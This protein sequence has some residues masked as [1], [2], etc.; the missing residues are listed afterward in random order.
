[1]FRFLHDAFLIDM[2]YFL[3]LRMKNV[4]TTEGFRAYDNK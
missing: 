1:M 3:S 2:L 4:V